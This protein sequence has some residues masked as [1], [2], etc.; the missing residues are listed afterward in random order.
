MT[1]HV[2]EE[3]RP[4]AGPATG[5]IREITCYAISCADCGDDCWDECE[6]TPHFDSQAELYRRLFKDDGWTHGRHR[7]W[8]CRTCTAKADCGRDGHPWGEWRPSRIDREVA[9][10]HCDRCGRFEDVLVAMLPV[11]APPGL[12]TTVTSTGDGHSPAGRVLSVLRDP[13]RD[14][15]TAAD[16]ALW[17]GLDHHLVVNQLLRL[18]AVGVVRHDHYTNTWKA[19]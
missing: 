7:R 8:L 12:G 14:E 10:R 15:L 5:V 18:R 3:A 11:P 19:A 16:V 6:F 4:A 17:T 9:W 13:D 2:G 1:P